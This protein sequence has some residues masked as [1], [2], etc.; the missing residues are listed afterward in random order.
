MPTATPPKKGP[1]LKL[2]LN[3]TL[4]VASMFIIA[5]SLSQL[6]A[7]ASQLSTLKQ[8]WGTYSG[9]GFSGSTY[10]R[11]IPGLHLAGHTRYVEASLFTTGTHSKLSATSHQNVMLGFPFQVYD[12]GWFTLNNTAGVG[13]QHNMRLLNTPERQIS[14]QEDTF[15]LGFGAQA[16]L[17]SHLCLRIEGYFGLTSFAIGQVYHENAMG[18][19]GFAL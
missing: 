7:A 6:D 12:N 10:G 11:S 8:S 16:C 15:G 4:G 13:W 1:Q 14:S 9:I 5:G 19:I 17:Y 18:S 2:L 3:S